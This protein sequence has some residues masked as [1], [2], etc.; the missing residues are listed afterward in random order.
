VNNFKPNTKTRKAKKNSQ[1]NQ[2]EAPRE[3]KRDSVWS[4]TRAAE[5]KH[6]RT[7][8]KYRQ[9]G[10]VG[11]SMGTTKSE[12]GGRK[13]ASL[14]SKEINFTSLKRNIH[15]GNRGPKGKRVKRR[16]TNPTQ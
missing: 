8:Y 7:D 1:V 2:K 10:I 13:I 9:G 16:A 11:R 4:C 5:R 12:T 15:R 14:E 6:T 3:K